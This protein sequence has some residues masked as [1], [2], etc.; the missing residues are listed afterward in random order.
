MFG[1]FWAYSRALWLKIEGNGMEQVSHSVHDLL[2]KAGRFGNTWEWVKNLSEHSKQPFKVDSLRLSLSFFKKVPVCFWVHNSTSM[3]HLGPLLRWSGTDWGGQLHMRCHPGESEPVAYDW[4]CHWLFIHSL[5]GKMIPVQFN[6]Y[7]HIF[8]R[9]A[10][11]NQLLR[12][13]FW[14][15]LVGFRGM[16]TFSEGN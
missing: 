13:L 5:L 6:Y 9:A 14:L 15:V 8:G 7:Y 4:W 1:R 2:N 16:K 10:N 12:R 3:V 11:Y